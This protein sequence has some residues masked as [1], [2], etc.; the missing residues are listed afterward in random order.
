MPPLLP[1]PLLASATF[2]PIQF[3]QPIWLLLIPILWALTLW[4]GRKS[5]SGLA[6]WTRRVSLLVRLIVIALLAGAMAEPQWRNESRDVAVTV[7]LDTSKSVQQQLQKDVAGFVAQA[8]ESGKKEPDRLGVVTTAREALVQAL[9]S[10]L[11]KAVEVQT[12]GSAEA[13]DLAAGVRMALAIKPE[14][15]AY[16]IALFSDGNETTG[17][18]LQAAEGAKAAGVPIDVMPLAYK[19]EDEVIVDQLVVP[20]TARMGEN[21]SLKVVLTSKSKGV[22]RGR[23]NI[24]LNDQPINLDPE[25]HASGLIVDLKEGVNVFAV[26][27]TVPNAGAQQFKAVFEPLA[28]DRGRVADSIAENNTA[29]GVTF[30]TSEGRVLIITKEPEAAAELQRALTQS[31]IASDVVSAEQAPQSLTGLSA[32]DAIL[33]VNASAYDFSEKSQQELRQYIHDSGGGLVMIGGPESYGAGGWIGSPLEDALPVRLDP[34]QK[35]QMPRGA[36]VMVV[37]SCEIPQGVY[38]GKK[39]C[40]SAVAALS[41]LDMA[42]IIEYGYAGGHKWTFPL[43]VIGDGSKARMAIQNM[44]FG[45]MPEYGTSLGMAFDA[46]V[47]CDAGQKHVIMISDGDGASPSPSLIQKYIKNK[48]TITTVGC[49]THSSADS[50]R[51]QQ[52][53]SKPTGGKH[54]E[55]APQNVS[56]LPEIFMKEAQTVKRSLIWEGTPFVPTMVNVASEAMRG[57]TAIPPISGYVVTAEREGL[58]LVSLKGKENDP[59]LAQWQYGLGKV[60]AYTSD[61]ATRWNSA[62]IGW[63]GYKAFWEQH[64]RWAMRPGGS[65][66]LR[67]STEN[68]GDTTRVVVDML[69][70]AGERLNFASIRARVAKPDGTGEDV[71]MHQV[72]PGRYQTIVKSDRSGSYLFS[73]QYAAPGGSGGKPLVGSAQAAITR[74]FAD[75]FR[76]LQDNAALLEQV[77]TMTGGRVLN[78]NWQQADLWSREGLKMPVALRPIWL[79]VAIAGIAMFLMDVAVR[80]VRIDVV[81]IAHALAGL[82][83]RGRATAAHQM[84]SLHAAREKAKQQM[85]NRGGGAAEAGPDAAPAPMAVVPRPAIVDKAAREAAKIKFEASPEALAKRPASAPVALGAEPPPAKGPAA[86]GPPKE[87]QTAEQGMSR[88]LQAKQRARD[89]IDDSV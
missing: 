14:D 63:Q 4:I 60:V 19:F 66:N 82:A 89:E 77:A 3:D 70:A 10:K 87:K 49:A 83:S 69:D 46:L 58:A 88:L 7:I 67:V 48:I 54:Y 25:G 50:S 9:P 47:R 20:A 51:M 43:E 29:L 53:I 59:I 15:A 45:D 72:G 34:P 30:V 74:P 65:A 18:L 71:D 8:T 80:R 2:G 57:I 42:G 33:L 39:I 44:V 12:T 84:D 27:I 85:A 37:H 21:L 86:K 68:L 22:A 62:W 38:Y 76:A 75:E 64:V 79:G 31:K 61:A 73:M 24:L 32:Y 6:T 78:P 1:P 40:E 13:T 26:P 11:N 17:S 28:D 16:R 36:L 5:L 41:R 55:I 35:R 56:K 23:L 52:D 81:A